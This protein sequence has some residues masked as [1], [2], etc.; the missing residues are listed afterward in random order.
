MVGGQGKKS[1][2]GLLM[3]AQSIGNKLDELR[4]VITMLEPNIVAVTETWTNDALGDA[5]LGVEGYEIVV[6]CDRGDTAGGRGGG[7]LIYAERGVCMWS[8]DNET[9]F[10][11]CV[12][13]KI[14]TRCEELNFHVVYRSP[15][16]KKENDEELC[17]WVRELRGTNILIGDFNFPDVDWRDGRAG[18]KGRN[19]FDA[20]ASRFMEQLVDTP[21]H[22]SG[23]IL[24]LVLCDRE[25]MVT[26]VSTK[27]RIGKSDHEIVEFE[28]KTSDNSGKDQRKAADYRRANFS[29]MRAKLGATDWGPLF[30]GKTVDEAWGMVRERMGRLMQEHI[31]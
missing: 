30:R 5:L 1:L 29:E 17:R 10:N 24:D 7:I 12:S 16:S 26:S 20:T 9:N 28:I 4:T 27:G 23:N 22:L 25:G 18:A 3:N 13:T 19:F 15:N 8:V 14:K 6:R 2:K 31:P 11:Q 21:T